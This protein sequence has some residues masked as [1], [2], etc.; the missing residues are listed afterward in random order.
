[1]TRKMS[2]QIYKKNE[3]TEPSDEEEINELASS[4]KQFQET[5]NSDESNDDTDVESEEEGKVLNEDR[6]DRQVE[7]E[8]HDEVAEEERDDQEE[9]EEEDDDGEDTQSVKTYLKS[10]KYNQLYFCTLQLVQ[11]LYDNPS[12]FKMS[13]QMNGFNWK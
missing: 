10:T 9:E 8:I 11:N 3:E 1:M 5:N 2:M 7:Y 4:E 6:G 12:H 13:R